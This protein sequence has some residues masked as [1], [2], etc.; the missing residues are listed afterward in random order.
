M[1]LGTIQD[2]KKDCRVQIPNRTNSRSSTRHG[3][4]LADETIASECWSTVDQKYGVCVGV[5]VECAVTI[6]T[7]G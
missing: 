3:S 1:I 4:S 6:T 5:G 7:T 2:S